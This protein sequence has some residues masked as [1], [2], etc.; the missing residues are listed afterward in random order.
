M[1]SQN[2]SYGLTT[3]RNRH[4]EVFSTKVCFEF[5]GKSGVHHQIELRDPRLARAIKR[6]QQL[7]GY[8]LF[9]YLDQAGKRQTIDSG[10][11][12]QYLEMITG[13]SFTAKEFRTWAGT[14]EAVS[15]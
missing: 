14:V 10:D 8:Q 2:S 3:L 6:C 15:A 13:H 7:P 4:V 11:V 12:N 5:T 1:R 9:Q